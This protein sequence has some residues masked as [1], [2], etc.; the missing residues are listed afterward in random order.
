MVILFFPKEQ[1]QKRLS[2]NEFSEADKLRPETFH[3]GLNL[4]AFPDDI[5]WK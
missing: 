4:T 5:F 3:F 1:R 2:Q